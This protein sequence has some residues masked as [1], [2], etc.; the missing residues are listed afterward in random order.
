MKSILHLQT[1]GPVSV[2]TGVWLIERLSP[3][4]LAAVAQA[5]GRTVEV[6]LKDNGYVGPKAQ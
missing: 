5:S 3:A 2:K 6:L 1:S 4:S